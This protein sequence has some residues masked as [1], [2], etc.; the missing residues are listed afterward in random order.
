MNET[1]IKLC[2]YAICKNEIE[3]VEKWLESVKEADEVV[4]LDTGSTDGTW[5][6]LQQSGVKCYQKI[7]DPFR[8]DS[9][10]NYALSLVPED[11]EICLP[12]DI[13]SRITNGFCKKIKNAWLKDTAILY[14]PRYFTNTNNSDRWFVHA[15]KDIVWAYPVYEQVKYRGKVGNNVNAIIT[16]VWDPNR[17]SHDLYLDLAK[18]GVEEN[19]TDPYCL[20]ALRQIEKEIKSKEV[21][22][23]RE[24]NNC[25]FINDGSTRGSL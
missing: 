9:A 13:D 8:F 5:E 17:P 22:D 18:L 20:M 11:C 10:R 19:P 25:G 4:V 15:R 21:T 16:C 24:T 14:I 1:T 7:F 12:L 6:I 23:E 3:Y 2:I